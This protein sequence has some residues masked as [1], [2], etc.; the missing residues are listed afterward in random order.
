MLTLA[1]WIPISHTEMLIE[2]IFSGLRFLM[3]RSRMYLTAVFICDLSVTPERSHPPSIS[4]AHRRLS[5]RKSPR[6]VL[7]GALLQEGAL[8]G[9][10]TIEQLAPPNL[11]LRSRFQIR[12]KRCSIHKSVFGLESCR[13]NGNVLRL[14]SY[15]SRSRRGG[16]S[17]L[18]LP[19]PFPFSQPA[20]LSRQLNGVRYCT[21]PI[22]DGY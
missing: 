6:L 2:S 1:H 8:T 5:L 13:F 17:L 21:T 9:N 22:T 7:P 12:K 16:Q 11:A 20:C 14:R 4:C 18:V 3:K 19:H 10:Q 15:I